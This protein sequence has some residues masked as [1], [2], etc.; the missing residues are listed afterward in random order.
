MSYWLFKEEPSH[1]SFDDLIRE[2]ADFALVRISRLSVMPVTPAQWREI[3][4]MGK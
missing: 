2:F 4:R 1:Y 3:Q